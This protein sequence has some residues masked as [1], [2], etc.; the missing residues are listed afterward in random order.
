MSCGTCRKNVLYLPFR[1]QL[2]PGSSDFALE[3]PGSAKVKCHLHALEVVPDF[4]NRLAH[5]LQLDR[6]QELEETFVETAGV[7]VTY[8]KTG[9]VLFFEHETKKNRPPDIA[10]PTKPTIPEIVA[11]FN[12]CF[13]EKKP[14]YILGSP[15]FIDWVL[16][17]DK[18]NPI[19]N[20][21][22]FLDQNFAFYYGSSQDISD[23]FDALPESVRSYYNVNNFKIPL[24]FN[25]L[26]N[27]RLRVH[28]APHTRLA[29]F[30]TAA[31]P[32]SLGF[33]QKAL[34]PGRR[35]SLDFVNE[36]WPSFKTF[37][38]NV[39]PPH[40][41]ISDAV[42]NKFK[43]NLSFVEWQQT[44]QMGLNSSKLEDP[45]HLLAD[46]NAGLRGIRPVTNFNVKGFFNRTTNQF[47]FDFPRDEANLTIHLP[48][49]VAGALGFADD[50]INRNSVPNIIQT[51]DGR[52]DAIMKSRT[53]AYDT[54]LVYCVQLQAS[55]SI[56]SGAGEHLVAF[57]K[58]TGNGRLE[59]APPPCNFELRPLGQQGSELFGRAT[60]DLRLVKVLNSG[61]LAP[62]NWE[63]GAVVEGLL[64]GRECD[65]L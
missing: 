36:T 2:P 39:R 25:F 30:G 33:L 3:V 42:P 9:K 23:V 17:D 64:V 26:D 18:G 31:L 65:C 14:P 27:F 4:F 29:M 35:N 51:D 6:D 43:I 38:A 54:G 40:E 21:H 48:R 55:S 5:K 8:P 16:L 10:K 28:L 56:F 45:N 59:R 44:F 60:V 32:E 50:A 53:L 22:E 12:A 24:N 19:R 41:K 57:L 20:M 61:K 46:L 47:A 7:S 52:F 13:E 34:V 63:C 37:L 62:L 49:A 11:E 1:K 15:A 58:P